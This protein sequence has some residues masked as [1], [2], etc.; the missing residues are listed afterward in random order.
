MINTFISKNTALRLARKTTKL[1]NEIVSK[2]N[3]TRDMKY[4]KPPYFKITKKLHINYLHFSV[5]VQMLYCFFFRIDETG[6]AF[7]KFLTICLNYPIVKVFHQV[8][9]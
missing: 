3:E 2:L 7:S 9:A 4:F 8:L 5:S 1:I 6:P